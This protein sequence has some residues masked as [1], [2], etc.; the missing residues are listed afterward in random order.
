[1]AGYSEKSFLALKI[2]YLVISGRIF[3]T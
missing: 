3:A 2:I 1:M